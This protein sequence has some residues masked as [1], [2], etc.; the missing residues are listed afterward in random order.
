MN[1]PPGRTL[2]GALI[3]SRLNLISANFVETPGIAHLLSNSRGLSAARDDSPV[4]NT[5]CVSMRIGTTKLSLLKK[6][7]APHRAIA[8]C[9]GP[10]A[11]D[12]RMQ[13]L[14]KSAMFVRSA[15]FVA[16]ALLFVDQQPESILTQ[17]PQ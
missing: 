9:V 1:Y 16:E 17:T 14:L 4:T 10:A 12:G 3:L 13:M 8:D 15:M 5:R 2:S 7:L 6:F 11:G